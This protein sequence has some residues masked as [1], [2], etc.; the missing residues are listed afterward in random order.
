[1]Y[2]FFFF[3]FSFQVRNPGENPRVLPLISRMVPVSSSCLGVTGGDHVSR[4]AMENMIYTMMMMMIN[5]SIDG[6]PTTPLDLPPNTDQLK[7]VTFKQA[8]VWGMG[9]TMRYG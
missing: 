9:I 6:N 5:M 3:L 1:M 8:R 2:M 4:P 7:L